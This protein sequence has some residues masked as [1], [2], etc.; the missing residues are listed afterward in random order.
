MTKKYIVL[1]S[2]FGSGAR[3]LGKRLSEVLGIKFMERKTC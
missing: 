2:E 3:L 1:T